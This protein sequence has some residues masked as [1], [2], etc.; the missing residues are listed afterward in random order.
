[1]SNIDYNTENM[2]I[3]QTK[4]KPKIDLE[5]KARYEWQ[6]EQNIKAINSAKKR[7]KLLV[8]LIPFS[9]IL[10]IGRLFFGF[11]EA[12]GF[13]A[14]VMLICLVAPFI[15]GFTVS[16]LLVIDDIRVKSL[17]KQNDMLVIK[18]KQA[19][20]EELNY[21]ETCIL[22]KE[23]QTYEEKWNGFKDFLS[24]SIEEGMKK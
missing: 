18:I 17:T 8:L 9:F 20:G 7:D 12:H 10:F 3:T 23:N 2:N 5:S 11:R 21:N 4:E 16:I 6:L 14:L 13:M 19:S 1:M 15:L 24:N 22:D